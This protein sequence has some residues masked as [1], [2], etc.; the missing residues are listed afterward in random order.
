MIKRQL[1]R[2]GVGGQ[3]IMITVLYLLSLLSHL[4]PWRMSLERRPGVHM[5]IKEQKSSV[6]YFKSPKNLL[7]VSDLPFSMTY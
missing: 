3:G 5:K 1:N 4:K 7:F 2:N 6:C